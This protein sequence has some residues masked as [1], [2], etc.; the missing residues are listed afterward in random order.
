[1]AEHDWR[2]LIVPGSGLDLE[3][4]NTRAREAVAAAMRAFQRLDEP[5]AKNT[6]KVYA[7]ALDK[8]GEWCDLFAFDAFPV[9]PE[10]L[11]AHLEWLSARVTR[12]GAPTAPSTVRQSMSAICSVDRW[13]RTTP[14]DPFPVSVAMSPIVQR[15]LTNWGRENK[16]A[17]VKQAPAL[18]VAQVRQVVEGIEPRTKSAAFAPWEARVARDRAIWL[19]GIGGALRMGELQQMLLSHTRIVD[20]GLLLWLPRAKNDQQGRGTWKGIMRSGTLSMCPVLAYERW[21]VARGEWE[22]PL[23][24]SIQRTGE[25]GGARLDWGTLDRNLKANAA[26]VGLTVS[27]HSLRRTFATVARKKRMRSDAIQKHGGWKRQDTMNKYFALED[28][29]DDNPTAGLFDGE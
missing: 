25:L 24:V 5:G 28:V 23:F 18:T 22:G 27:T 29:W 12:Y 1:M 14:E 26:R 4:R 9:T 20:R 2:Q 13:R 8:W 19:I 11:I 10:R 16:E 21:L 3:V 17:P 6:E 15:W 7:R